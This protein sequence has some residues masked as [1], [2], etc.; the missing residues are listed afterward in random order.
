MAQN[1]GQGQDPYE[2]LQI[3]VARM[4]WDDDSLREKIKDN[5]KDTLEKTLSIKLPDNLNIKVIDETEA[6]TLYLLL[7]HHPN[8]AYGFELTSDQ[9]D[10]VAGGAGLLDS[11]RALRGRMDPSSVQISSPSFVSA[12]NSQ[13][14]LS[15]TGDQFQGYLKPGLAGTATRAMNTV[16]GWFGS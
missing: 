5:P 6:N 13:T 15:V 12:G 11:A 4:V 1:I 3:T 9:L 10:K 8:Q 16:K 14:G 7:P 2:A